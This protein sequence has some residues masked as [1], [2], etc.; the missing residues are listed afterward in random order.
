VKIVTVRMLVKKDPLPFTEK[1]VIA[2]VRFADGSVW[3][4]N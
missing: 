4:S 2:R 1:V 3:E